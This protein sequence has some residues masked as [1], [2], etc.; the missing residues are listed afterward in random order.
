MDE[1]KKSLT[2]GETETRRRAVLELSGKQSAVAVQ[3]LLRAMEDT[4]WR[5]RKTASE[6]LTAEYPLEQYV[7]GLIKLL[8]IEENAGA[9]NSAIETLVKLGKKVTASL[10]DAFDAANRD[11]RKFIVDIIGEVKDRKALPLL[12]K[13]LKDEDDNVK[14]SA[15]E[16]LGQMGDKSVVDALIEILGGEDVWTAFPAADALGRIG[17]KK[18]V[19]ALLSALK[20]K[21]LR[22]SVLKG[23]G[24]LSA[25]ETLEYIVP[26]LSDPSRTIQE[27]TIRT[28]G[29]FYHSGVSADFI[30]ETMNRLSG[31]EMIHKLAKHAWS[32]KADVRTTAILLL[33][34]MQDERALAPLLELYD[35]ESVVEDVKRA[36]VFIGKRRPESLLP[37]F[38]SDNEYQ[39]RLIAEVA[40]HVVSPVY[41]D[42]FEDILSDK[43]GHVRAFAAI[44]LSRLRDKGA[45]QSLKKLLS[46]PYEDIQEAAVK[47]L[48]DLRDGLDVGEF[49]GCLKDEDI[50]LRRNAAL[51]L[52]RIGAKEGVGDL[53]FALKDADV[54]VRQAVV[55]ALS[56]LDTEEA[57]K[58]LI[59]ALTDEDPYIRAS[60]ALSLGSL[61]TKNIDPLLLLLTDSDDA[62]K[63]A[64][65]RAIGMTGETRAVKHLVNMLTNQ[66]GFVVTTAIESLGRLG[67]DEAGK[68]VAGM[69]GS[70]DSEIRRTAIR[71]LSF[72]DGFEGA[73]TPFLHDPDWA[74]RVAAVETLSRGPSGNVREQVEE[75]YDW[76][77]DPAVRRAVEE[78]F[79]VR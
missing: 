38:D 5:V 50:A 69:L 33:G 8:T 4:S 55:E 13:A 57:V 75:L 48:S 67:G 70:D 39:R 76:E 24:H 46:D 21:A 40:G 12:L 25:P 20:V 29:V 26:F 58:Y 54:S 41:R 23:L 52:G 16:H 59:F 51:L 27:E 9:R 15:V 53:G 77:E 65:I 6:I 61:G 19:P 7:G 78:C 14:A 45:V 3:Q 42:L 43:D 11:V 35:E 22:E 10:V 74:T 64:A 17:D 66:N 36:L 71:S 2:D 1:M 47:A 18:A 31:T 62:V 49:I 68:A 30:S 73:V 28:I 63:V 44:G 32:A 60:A 34:L 72:F 37:L 56:S 79:G